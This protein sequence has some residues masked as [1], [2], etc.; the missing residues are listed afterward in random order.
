MMLEHYIKLLTKNIEEYDICDTHLCLLIELS[1]VC[2]DKV[3]I[4]LYDHLVGDISKN[5]ACKK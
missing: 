3:I 1:E 4:S 2:N 5:N